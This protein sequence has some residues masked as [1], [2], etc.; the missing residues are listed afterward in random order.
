MTAPLIHCP[1]CKAAL[2]SDVFNRREFVP[3]PVCTSPLEIE[4]FPAM[5]RPP[6]EAHAGEAVMMEGE[7]SCFYHPAKKAVLPCE[8]CG[9]FLCAL[10]DCEH[11]G[12]HFC[13]GCL[14]TGQKKGKIRTLDNARVRYDNIA[15]ALA[16]WPIIPPILFVG[17]YLLPFTATAAIIVAIKYW[18]SPLGLTQKSRARFVIAVVLALLELAAITLFIIAIVTS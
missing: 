12:Q 5:F 15:L 4:V 10:C 8:S 2:V 14:A 3:C 6:V 16:L 13:P 18:K 17:F 7:A 11:H 1:K 9:R